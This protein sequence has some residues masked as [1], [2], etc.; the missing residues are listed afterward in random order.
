MKKG[1]TFAVFVAFGLLSLICDFYFSTAR[2]AAAPLTSE[3]VHWQS[4]QSAVLDTWGTW[5]G[6]SI[7]VGD[8]PACKNETVVYRFVPVAGHPHQIRQLADKIIDGKRIPMGALTFDY[9]E[10][11]GKLTCEFTW[12]STHGIWSFSIAGDS[13]TGKLEML[14]ERTIGRDVK[15]HRVKDSEVPAAPALHEYD[16]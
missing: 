2:I 6:T 11:A 1:I 3:R 12:G 4:K 16:G 14:P 10:P 5:T 7:C 9:D 13:M 15:V 8:R